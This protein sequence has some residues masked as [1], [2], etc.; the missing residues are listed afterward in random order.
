MD[1]FKYVLAK[2]LRVAI[3]MQAREHMQSESYRCTM[4]CNADKG[5]NCFP[6]IGMIC[7]L[8]G[9]LLYVVVVVVTTETYCRPQ[10]FLRCSTFWMLY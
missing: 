3:A 4:C 1:E 8:L 9:A 2:R 7:N 10:F 6:S 5:Q